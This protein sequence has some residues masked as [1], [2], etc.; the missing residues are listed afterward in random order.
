M[1]PIDAAQSMTRHVS[2]RRM[3]TGIGSTLRP[4]AQLPC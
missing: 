4:W 2:P 1:I 3:D